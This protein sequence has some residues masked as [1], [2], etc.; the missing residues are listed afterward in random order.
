MAAIVYATPERNGFFSRPVGIIRERAA[1]PPPLPGQPGPFSLGA[2]GVLAAVFE[3][4]GLRDID[5]ANV[6]APLH[7]PSAAECVRFQKESF[8]ALHQMMSGLNDAE[9]EDVWRE[10]GEA[11]VEYETADGFCGAVRIG[12]CR[13]SK[14]IAAARSAALTEPAISLRLQ[15]RVARALEEP[16]SMRLIGSYRS[17]FAR[18]VGI[19]LNVLAIPFELEELLASK[20]PEAVSGYH[21]LKRIPALV[22]DDGE[23]LVESAAI[24][25]ALDDMVGPDRALVPPTGKE[26]RHTMKL[27]SIALGT[28]DKAQWAFYEGRFHPPEKVHQPWIDHNEDQVL[29]G[30]AY[31]DSSAASAGPDGWLGLP[32]RMTQADITGTVA[33]SFVQAFRPHLNVADRF[34]NLRRLAERCE[35]MEEFRAAAAPA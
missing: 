21:P 14:I 22:W 4:A 33:Y 5:V 8:G 31:L 26:R 20:D 2:D 29:S 28:I 35:A 3:Q 30:L 34:T 11:L 27:A 32:D 10:V 9:K 12:H 13:R 23:V 24:L 18:R 17:P 6:D 19:S 25:D 7:M 1:L 16:E 15:S